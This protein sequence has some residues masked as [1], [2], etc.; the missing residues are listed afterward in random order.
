M[1]LHPGTHLGSFEIVGRLGSGGM[2]EVYRARDPRL[3]REVALKVLPEEF[4]RDAE[5]L[6]R[7][8]RE[9]RT[10]AGLNHPNIVTMFSVEDDGGT[11]FLTMELVE[12]H[13]LDQLITAGGLEP[14]RLLELAIPLADALVAAHKKGVVHRDLKPANV[15][16][17]R[18]GRVKVLDFGLA[19]PARP[20]LDQDATLAMSARDALSS[21]GLVLGTVPYMAPEQVRG[22]ALDARTDLFAF[23]VLLYELATGRRPFVGATSADVSSAILRDTPPAPVAVRADLPGDLD[24]IIRR[25]LEKSPRDR[26]QSALEVHNEL[27]LLA[28]ALEQGAPRAAKTP[29]AEKP[30]IAVLPFSNMSADPENEYFSDGL[31]EELLNVLTKIPELKVT[32]R[33][34]SFAF[35]GKNQDLREIGEKLGVATL[36]EGSVRKAGNRVRITAQLIKVADGFHLWS[37]TYDRVLDDIFAVQ[38]DIARSVSSALH[39][40][41]LGKGAATPRTNPEGYELLLR[42]NHFASRLTQESLDKAVSLYRE[43]IAKSPDDARVW[44]GLARALS[45]QGGYGYTDVHEAQEQTRAALQRALALDDSSPV[46][47]EML[48][49]FLLTVE[50]EWDRAGEALRRA[51]SLAPGSSGPLS[52]LALYE[53]SRGRLEAAVALARRAVDCDPLAPFVHLNTARIE[54]MAGHLDRARDSYVTALELS[55]DITSGRASLGLIYLRLGRVEEAVTEI[56]KERSGGYRNLGFAIAYHVLDRERESDEA[57]ARLVN[58]GEEWGIQLAVAHAVRGEPDQAFE[59]LERAFA[60]HDQGV[61]TFRSNPWLESLHSDPRWAQFLKKVGL[62]R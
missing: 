23:G 21:P 11:R 22:E 10:V 52:G 51:E 41:L 33:T 54:M 20:D 40:T 2:G 18:E 56:E 4:S 31:S 6:A 58:E 47:H 28:R 32:G 61:C 5:R 60:L 59:W 9:A 45:I 36:L 27:R 35:K 17:D 49:L 12:G 13:S 43:A 55:P 24:R 37:E 38:D 19:T 34:S 8:E 46:V 42:A 3:G 14:R 50:Y 44:A 48:G 39:V 57:L 15:M 25:C 16:V 1:A 53:A 29:G 7:F 30:S 62:T 26:F